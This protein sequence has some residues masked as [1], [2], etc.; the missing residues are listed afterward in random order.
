MR[1]ALQRE[2]RQA[3]NGGGAPGARSAGL[4]EPRPKRR[5]RRTTETALVRNADKAGAAVH[6]DA[7]RE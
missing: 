6:R 3:G 1:D 4:G 5:G 7:P 2:P